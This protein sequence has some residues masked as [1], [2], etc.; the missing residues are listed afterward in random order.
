M[1]P[2][3]IIVTFLPPI[4]AYDNTLI[5]LLKNITNKSFVDKTQQ[6]RTSINLPLEIRIALDQVSN[7]VGKGK[8]VVRTKCIA[9]GHS[10]LQ[11]NYHDKIKELFKLREELW[12]SKCKMT[13]ETSYE[14]RSS[15]N[16]SSPSS[17][18][19]YIY[20]PEE[21]L[22]SIDG[23][24]CGLG[25]SNSA[26]IRICIAYSLRTVEIKEIKEK[27]RILNKDISNFQFALIES[28][29]FLY[30]LKKGEE[31]YRKNIKEHYNKL[32]KI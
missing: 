5:E 4:F 31:H 20:L 8:N 9:H 32:K 18:N 1:E 16:L 24:S 17:K 3:D 29:S 26:V 10:I 2:D 21:I 7:H 12:M 11:H 13:R 6:N 25:I 28:E 23:I 15:C 27:H 14:F 22:A 19:I 30:G